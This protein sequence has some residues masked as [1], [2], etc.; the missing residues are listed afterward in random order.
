[1]L[2]KSKLGTFKVLISRDLID[3]YVNHEEFVSVSNVFSG[4]NET[5]VEYIIEIWLI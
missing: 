2:G 5:N 1:M 4:D 3:L